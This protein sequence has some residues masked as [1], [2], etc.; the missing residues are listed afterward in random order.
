[1]PGISDTTQLVKQQFTLVNYNLSSST[2][3]VF[4]YFTLRSSSLFIE[5]TSVGIA[6]VIHQIYMVMVFLLSIIQIKADRSV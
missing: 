6:L 1:M 4:S 2:F 3:S 5:Y